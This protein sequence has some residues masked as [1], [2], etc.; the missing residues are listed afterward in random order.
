MIAQ[1]PATACPQI[2]VTARQAAKMLAVSERTLWTLT[3]SGQIRRLKIGASVRYSVAEL[4]RFAD[5]QLQGHRP[6]S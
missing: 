1:T 3:N 4:Q 6:E 2:L 5:S